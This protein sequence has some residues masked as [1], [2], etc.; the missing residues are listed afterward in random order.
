MKSRNRSSRTADANMTRQATRKGYKRS[1]KV[2]RRPAHGAIMSRVSRDIRSVVSDLW[3][4][5]CRGRGWPQGSKRRKESDQNRLGEYNGKRSTRPGQPQKK[6]QDMLHAS[7]SCEREGLDCAKEGILER[8]WTSR[9]VAGVR[10][11]LPHQ[12]DPNASASEGRQG[13]RLAQ[14]FPAMRGGG[15]RLRGGAWTGKSA[16]AGSNLQ[17]PGG[18][19]R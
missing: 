11:R 13:G 17:D 12:K 18:C 9:A 4:W 6:V 3:D 8:H 10:I 7:R 19:M 14:G 2:C 5:C 16:A 15:Q 1:S